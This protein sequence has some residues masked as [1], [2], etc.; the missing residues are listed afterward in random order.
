[1]LH[2]FFVRGPRVVWGDEPFYL[3]LGHNL[4]T[5]RGYQFVG[6]N[7][8]HHPPLFPLLAGLLYLAVGSLEQ[9]S[10]V[11]YVVLGSLLVLPMAGIGRRMYGPWAG[12]FVGLL[13]ALWPVFNAAVP[14]WGTMTEPP[15]FFF[16][17][18]GL[19]AAVEVASADT[20]AGRPSPATH[21][22]GSRRW[23]VLW[24]LAGLAFG[25]AYLTRPEGIWYVATVGLAL[26]AVAWL[27]RQPLRHWLSGALLYALGFA[28]CF[29]PYAVYTRVHTGA[30]MV[31]QKVGITFQ[32]SLALAR[33][34]LAEH[35]RI[36][37]Q[38]DSTGERVFF[39]SEESFHL[40]ML[41]AIRAKPRR[42]AGLVYLNVRSLLGR[43]FTVQ[44]FLPALLP[45]LGLGLFGLAWDRRRLRGEAVLLAGLLPPLTFLLFFIFERYVAPLLLPLLIWTGLG[46]ALLC[47]W[48]RETAANLLPRLGRRSLAVATA[49]PALAL[50]A[51]LAI[52]HPETLRAVRA[53]QAFRAEHR[54]A[55]EWLAANAPADA[56]VMARYPAIAFHANRYWL[57][58]PNSDYAAALRYAAANGA[59]YWVMD[60]NERAWRPQLAFLFEDRPPPEL[61]LVYRVPTAGQPVLVYRVLP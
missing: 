47:R 23:L 18:L 33:N 48:A 40:S 24:W 15:F 17:A 57:P 4:V 13:T 36:L 46:A 12:L 44:G 41:D 19:W 22:V 52:A 60:G 34:D 21:A 25:L 58:S 49:L 53:T 43:F 26:L 28:L 20:A 11:V 1:M 7:D 8:V 39:F 54:A 37:W 3:W 14:W 38:L 10:N 51:I 45:L 16:V 32:D 6:F 35:D 9:A 5:G 31:S 29:G 2:L 61:E 50:V 30:W 27:T 55:G 59:D 56:V 42:Y